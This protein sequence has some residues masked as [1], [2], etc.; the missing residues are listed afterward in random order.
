MAGIADELRATFLKGTTKDI[1]WRKRQLRQ[2]LRLV[3]ENDKAIVE[4]LQQDLRRPVAEGV[5]GEITPILI[6]THEA[7]KNIDQW[8]K[9]RAINT[10]FLQKPGSSAIMPKPKGVALIIAPWNFPF[11][12][13]MQPLVGALAAGCCAVVKP[14]EVS[15]ACSALIGRLVRKYLDPEAVRVVEGGVA[16][17]TTLLEQRW[18]HIFYTGNAE[19]ARVVLQKAAQHL[20]TVTLELG[21]K[22]P[23]LVDKNVN[24]EVA[25]RRL[26]AGKCLNSGQ[27]CVAPDY[28]LVHKSREKELLAALKECLDKF[29]GANPQQS[30]SLG[31]MINQRHFERVR[32]LI[33]ST[34][35]TVICGGLDKCDE[36]DKYIPPTIISN[37]SP[38]NPVMKEEIFGPLLPVIAVDNMQSAIDFVNRRP[39]PLALYIFSSNKQVID[40]VLSQTNSGGCC[41]NDTILHLANSNL[42]FGGVGPSG[43]GSYHG[44]AS[45]DTFSHF[46]STMYRATWF[47]LKDRYPPYTENLY[48]LQ[49]ILVGPIFPEGTTSVLAATAA[50]AAAFMLRSYL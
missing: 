9:V 3:N 6:E 8:V 5:L 48:M 22:S 37:P 19:V 16:V 14:S 18:D 32:G 46:R 39:H 50:T 13:A 35:G 44:K 24:I 40:K 49:K 17:A 47:D 41:V 20:T 25:C 21:G 11:A 45:F 4:A 30:P 38:D 42:P 31:R 29:Y 10:P 34:D 2:I 27:V 36:L 1:E 26:L 28:V 43:M 12:L 33:A 15:P 23:V 7:L